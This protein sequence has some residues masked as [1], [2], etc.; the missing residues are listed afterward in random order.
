LLPAPQ[1][2]AAEAAAAA[3]V[4][5][6]W[7]Q[8]LH[9]QPTLGL[10]AAAM[11]TASFLSTIKNYSIMVSTEVRRASQPN[12]PLQEHHHHMDKLG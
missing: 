3:A 7:L 8:M 10:F 9:H 4:A 2:A 6:S 11:L 1:W 12:H 5:D